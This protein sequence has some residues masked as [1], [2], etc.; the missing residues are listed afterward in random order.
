M[1][2]GWGCK[3]EEGVVLCCQVYCLLVLG[4]DLGPEGIV[5]SSVIY[6]C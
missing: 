1:V 3:G 4:L 2:G 6:E 5:S